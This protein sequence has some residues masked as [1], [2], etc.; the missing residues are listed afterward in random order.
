MKE[1]YVTETKTNGNYFI[2][3]T[4]WLFFTLDRSYPPRPLW[5][6]QIADCRGNPLSV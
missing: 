1:K 5:R 6:H 2:A 3:L 4:G